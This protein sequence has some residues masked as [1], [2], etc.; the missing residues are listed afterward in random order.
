ME[1]G[2][3]LKK[4]DQE[5]EKFYPKRSYKLDED[6]QDGETRRLAEVNPVTG[7]FTVSKWVRRNGQ[8]MC[9][10]ATVYPR[11][12]KD[13]EVLYY[14]RTPESDG[15]LLELGKSVE[16][17]FSDTSYVEKFIKGEINPDEIHLEWEEWKK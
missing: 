16:P 17:D 6:A 10:E 5:I 8:W 15:R 3:N 7:E 14:Y 2:L 11:L 12:V 1:E 4:L 13:E 9:Q